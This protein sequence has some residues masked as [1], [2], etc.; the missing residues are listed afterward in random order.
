MA[1]EKAKEAPAAPAKAEKGKEGEGAPAKPAKKG[2]NKKVLII[3]GIVIADIALMAGIGFWLVGRMKADKGP[4][5]AVE[6]LK[7]HEEEEKQRLEK[8][9]SMGHVLPKPLPFTV[10]IG[11][12]EESH[13]QLEWEGDHSADAGGGGHGGGAALDA[14]GQE[15]E[16]RMP[17]INDIIINILSSQSYADLVKPAG[18]QKIKESIVDEINAILPELKPHG[19]EEGK[20]EE[21]HGHGHE[22]DPNAVPPGK[23]RNAFFTE[24]IV[25]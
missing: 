3:A 12:D 18:K 15:I 4:D 11:G 16:K 7:K 10:N 13:F 24:F 23:I 17:K 2:L 22:A 25:Q 8:I 14:T 9:T 20:G 19:E 6:A 1:E 21:G 5:P